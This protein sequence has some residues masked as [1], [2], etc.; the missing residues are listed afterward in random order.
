MK[1]K[2]DF[3][4]LVDSGCDVPIEYQEKYPIYVL[5]LYI[6]YNNTV[7]KDRIDITPE[8]VYEK[9]EFEIPKTSSPSY[10]ETVDTFEKIYEDGYSKI[11]AIHISSNLSG[12]LNLVSLVSEEYKEKGI[13]TFIFDTKNIAI[14]SGMYAIFTAKHIDAGKNYEDTVQLLKSA[15]GKSRLF[16]C[17]ETLEFLY[18]GGKIGRVASLVGSVLNIKPIITCDEEGTYIIV[19]KERGRKKCIEK[20]INL[21]EEFAVRGKKAEITIMCSGKVLGLE[22]IKE[23]L[24][25]LIPNCI[26]TIRGQISPV[27]GVHVGPGLV[28]ISIFI[29]E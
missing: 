11:I 22:K 28:G 16:F 26:V 24:E 10:Q 18:K 20:A 7:Y 12:T 15:Y 4:I 17:I 3:A 13:M 14:G 9:L 23:R 6:N 8:E 29:L 1:N 5:P 19:G 27:L 21:A 25:Q 2:T